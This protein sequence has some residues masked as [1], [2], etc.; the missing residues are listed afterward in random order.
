MD[1]L[2]HYMTRCGEL[3]RELSARDQ[4][5]AELEKDAEAKNAILTVG[6]GLNV[7]GS[8]EAIR[9][10][11]DYILLDSKHPQEAIDVRRSLARALQEIE[12]ALATT[13]A[14]L[15]Q[16]REAIEVFRKQLSKWVVTS[17]YPYQV[18]GEAGES[19]K[20]SRL[21]Y[22]L[23]LEETQAALEAKEKECERLGHEN[24]VIAS[25]R[26][27]WRRCHAKQLDITEHFKDQ[28]DTALAEAKRLRMELAKAREEVTKWQINSSEMMDM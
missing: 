21:W 3:S 11:Q 14:A 9:R 27:Y 10:A 25:N 7:Y 5:I 17:H 15:V 6:N 19:I 4:R 8:F 12:A 2:E 23:R 16:E 18:L 24:G 13:Q 1:D 20:G 22:K 26:D 28:R